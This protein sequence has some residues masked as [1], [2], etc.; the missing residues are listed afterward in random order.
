MVYVVEVFFN[1]NIVVVEEKQ[2]P[3]KKEE[4][5][6]KKIQQSSSLSIRSSH[7][8]IMSSLLNDKRAEIV[9]NF[10]ESHAL[11]QGL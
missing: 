5:H 3:E 4:K 9:L 10:S 6:K 8:N 1:E 7:W 11:F 2:E